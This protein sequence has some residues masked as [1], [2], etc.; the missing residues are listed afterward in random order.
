MAFYV[1]LLKC[2]DGSLYCGY[3]KDLKARLKQHGSGKASR[4]TRSRLPVN[5]V[6]SE[7]LNSKS[8]ALKREAGIKRMPRKQKLALFR[9]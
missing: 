8:A 4:Y 5:L 3:A 1:Y 6:Y 9:K 7:K 2:R